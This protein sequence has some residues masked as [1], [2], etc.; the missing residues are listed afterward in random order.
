MIR[1]LRLSPCHAEVFKYIQ[2]HNLAFQLTNKYKIDTMVVYYQDY[3]V[4]F[5]ETVDKILD[6]L[7]LPLVDHQEGFE[8]G[9]EYNK[10]YTNLDKRR[11]GLLAKELASDETWSHIEQYFDKTKSNFF[12][13]DLSEDRIPPDVKKLPKQSPP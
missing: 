13:T 11:I 5:N 6:F 7:E 9:H 4:K 10:F 1:Q 2:W 8:P 3:A 12:D